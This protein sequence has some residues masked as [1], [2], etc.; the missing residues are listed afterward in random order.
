MTSHELLS[1]YRTPSASSTNSSV[2]PTREPRSAS[3]W[4]SKTFKRAFAATNDVGYVASSSS[5][6][7]ND[8]MS[9]SESRKLVIPQVQITEEGTKN[10]WGGSN[11][12]NGS[13]TTVTSSPNK[14]SDKISKDKKKKKSI[15]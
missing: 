11:G 8:R 3:S 4:L 6:T 13:H 12:S 7:P 2:S 5:S 1:Y 10:F 15:K 9:F 14:V